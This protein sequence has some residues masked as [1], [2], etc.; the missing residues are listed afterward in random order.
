V[1]LFPQPTT[2]PRPTKKLVMAGSTVLLRLP[3]PWP[4]PKLGSDSLSSSRKMIHPPA[5][6]PYDARKRIAAEALSELS[7][8]PRLAKKRAI[9]EVCIGNSQ[10]CSMILKLK[11]SFCR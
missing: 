9:S 5:Q 6:E 3:S 11:Q 7:K 8:A 2:S 10:V 1:I 4:S